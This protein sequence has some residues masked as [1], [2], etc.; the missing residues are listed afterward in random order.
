[1]SRHLAPFMHAPRFVA[2]ADRTASAVK[3]AAVRGGTT[4]KVPTFNQTAK[5]APF[6]V[7]RKFK[8]SA[9]FQIVVALIALFRAASVDCGEA[10]KLFRKPVFFLRAADR[11]VKLFGVGVGD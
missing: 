3:T 7:E 6:G 9:L 2:V 10:V 1:M 11:L 5:A 8:N 4:L